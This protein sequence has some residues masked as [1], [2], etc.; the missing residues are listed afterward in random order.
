MWRRQRYRL[1]PDFGDDH[2]TQEFPSDD[3]TKEACNPHH[4]VSHPPH[5][6]IA[7]RIIS[8]AEKYR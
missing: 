7:A 8:A 4:N 6:R 2:S 1:S 5:P 3:D